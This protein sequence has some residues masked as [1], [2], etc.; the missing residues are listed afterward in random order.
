MRHLIYFFALCVLTFS[1]I[2]NVPILSGQVP[3]KISYQGLLTTSAGTPVPDGSYD[4][5]FKIF[6]VSAGGSALW[7]ENQTGITIQRGTFNVFLGSVTTFNI[8]S[9][10]TLYVEVTATSGPAIPSPTTFSPRS[11]LTSSPYALRADTSNYATVAGTT[12]GAAGGD[13][14]GSYPNPAI[15]TDAVTSPKI[16]DKTIQRDDVQ[17]TFKAPY[18]DTADYAKTVPSGIVKKVVSKVFGAQSADSGGEIRDL[19]YGETFSSPPV[20]H[21]QAVLRSAGGG[22]LAGA[23]AYAVVTARTADMDITLYNRYGGSPLPTASVDLHVLLIE[24]F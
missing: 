2:G 22:L 12:G 23:V 4:L 24:K 19:S 5:T 15:A 7:T 1:I 11:E 3:N 17:S 10:Q 16:L 20:V 9:N 13:L 21:L 18:A 14:I 6:D 8:S